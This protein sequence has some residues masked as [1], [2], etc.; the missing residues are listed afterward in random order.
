MTS[1]TKAPCVAEPG[2]GPAHVYGFAPIR[3]ARRASYAGAVRL[4]P[5]GTVSNRLPLGRLRRYGGRMMSRNVQQKSLM[6]NLSERRISDI[7]LLEDV[8]L[9]ERIKAEFREMRGFSP[10]ATQAARLFDLPLSRCAS[11][12]DALTREGFVQRLPDGTYRI[13]SA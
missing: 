12:L 3:N 13:T 4:V 10:T 11:L 1:T 7:A 8:A 5:R 2:N 6:G 9:L